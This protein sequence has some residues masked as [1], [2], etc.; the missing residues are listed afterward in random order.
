MLDLIAYA[1]KEN[2]IYSEVILLC[3]DKEMESQATMQVLPKPGELFGSVIFYQISRFWCIAIASKNLLPSLPNKTPFI[4]HMLLEVSSASFYKTLQSSLPVETSGKIVYFALQCVVDKYS[5][6]E[7]K[8]LLY[9]LGLP[10]AIR[11]FKTSLKNM[12]EKHL[13]SENS[14]VWKTWNLAWHPCYAYS[15]KWVWFLVIS[16]LWII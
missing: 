1:F 11:H 15:A 10:S 7:N 12:P 5:W 2:L 4:I 13:S 9:T 3:I 6:R 14:K 8:C 16:M